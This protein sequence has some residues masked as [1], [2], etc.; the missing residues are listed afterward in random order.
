MSG[1]S[2]PLQI[3]WDAEAMFAFSLADERGKK[4]PMGPI[5]ESRMISRPYVRTLQ[6]DSV[7]RTDITAQG[8]GVRPSPGVFIG[9]PNSTAWQLDASDTRRRLLHG[10]LTATATPDNDR[11]QWQGTLDLPI[12]EIR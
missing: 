3:V 11:R 6:P 8:Y 4:I 10:V 5:E 9:L 1:S 2:S 12:V 7:L